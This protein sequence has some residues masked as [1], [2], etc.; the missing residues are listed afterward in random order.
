MRYMAGTYMVF[1][2]PKPSPALLPFFLLSVCQTVASPRP[3]GPLNIIIHLA[4]SCVG[5]YSHTVV[6]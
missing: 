5:T 1:S 6:L 4:V 2:T 3:S